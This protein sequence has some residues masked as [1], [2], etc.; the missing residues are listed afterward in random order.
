MLLES[1]SCE[2]NILDG[3]RGVL[4][5]T[6]VCVPVDYGSYCENFDCP[7]DQ[8]CYVDPDNCDLDDEDLYNSGY[9]PGLVYAYLTCDQASASDSSE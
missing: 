2:D 4:T 5:A 9:F 7:T 3:G 8:F 1:E 6:G